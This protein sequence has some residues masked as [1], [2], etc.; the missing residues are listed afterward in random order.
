[1]FF[2]DLVNKIGSLGTVVIER[3]QTAEAKIVQEPVAEE[4]DQNKQI[5]G[6]KPVNFFGDLTARLENRVKKITETAK[7]KITENN[8]YTYEA[9]KTQGPIYAG[10]TRPNRNNNPLNIKASPYT[11]EYDGVVGLEEKEAEDG[12]QFLLFR[13][14]E[15]GFKAAERLLQ[16]D[17]YI[18]LTVDQAVKRWSN[19]GYGADEIAPQLKGK[20]MGN[21]SEKE[22]QNL[23]INMAKR[24]GFNFN[25]QTGLD[26]NINTPQELS[27]GKVTTAPGSSTKFEKFHPGIDIAN[28]MGTPIKSFTNGIVVA[29]EQGKKQGDKGYGNYVI[30]KDRDGNLHR[31]SHMNKGY[32]KV[33]DA[34]LTGQEIGEIGNTGST[35]STSGGDGSHLD[36]R[37]VSAYGK[38]KNPLTYVKNFS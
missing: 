7:Q 30:V 13:T 22:L 9:P 23:V 28:S 11:M 18:G 25:R 38:Y 1:M 24:E 20:I 26:R 14:I 3:P 5:T 34:V 21:L 2:Q 6:E 27:L 36:Y 33:G 16:T 12:G 37:V 31:Y 29:L 32:V 8:T 10:D 35:Y 4:E 19:N 15:D 17:G